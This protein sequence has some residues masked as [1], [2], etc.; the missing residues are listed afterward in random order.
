MPNL[1]IKNSPTAKASIQGSGFTKKALIAR[2]WMVKNSRAPGEKYD[3]LTTNEE[4]ELVDC[5]QTQ[6]TGL[7]KAAGWCPSGPEVQV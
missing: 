6:G 1:R 3:A 2:M 7:E 4:F 5:Q